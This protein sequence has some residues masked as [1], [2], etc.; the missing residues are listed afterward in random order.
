MIFRENSYF[1]QEKKE[2][3]TRIFVIFSP[4]RSFFAVIFFPFN[5]RAVKSRTQP[6]NA[7]QKSVEI[8]IHGA[9]TCS[10]TSELISSSPEMVVDEVID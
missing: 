9:E 5:K 6:K 7:N 10:V 2:N 4:N 3:Y 1:Q 8:T